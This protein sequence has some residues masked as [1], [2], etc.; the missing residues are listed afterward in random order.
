[1]S[2]FFGSH[3]NRL[4][5]KGRVSVPA[6]F[7]NVLKKIACETDGPVS[8]ILRPSHTQACIEAWPLSRFE[9][10][11]EKLE[12]YDVFSDEYNALSKAIYGNAYE[13]ESDREGRI[14][15]SDKMLK[16]AGLSEGVLFMGVGATFE[17]WEPEAGGESEIAARTAARQI[18]L[19]GKSP[20]AAR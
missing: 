13:V 15:L 3:L 6:S 11:G 12:G 14:L 5:A 18:T 9:K 2:N 20:G 16:H 1:M 8:M 10:L 7:R 19:P 4:D 17:I